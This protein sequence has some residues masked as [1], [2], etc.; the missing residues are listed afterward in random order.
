[1]YC[2]YGLWDVVCDEKY[3]IE[4]Q[5]LIDCKWMYSELIDCLPVEDLQ[6][7]L[8]TRVFTEKKFWILTNIFHMYQIMPHF[9]WFEHLLEYLVC[10]GLDW[11]SYNNIL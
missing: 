5:T 6:G 8:M 3:N 7:T 4:L 11:Y 9:Y 10:Y 2:C 1:M